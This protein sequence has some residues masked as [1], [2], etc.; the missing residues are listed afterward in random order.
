MLQALRLAFELRK[1]YNLQMTQRAAVLTGDLIA[2][3]RAGR[4]ATDAA[5]TLIDRIAR[6]E[7]AQAEASIGFSRFRGDGW[8]IFCSDP[9][10]VFRLAV[11]V[12]AAL[13]SQKKLPGTRISAATGPFTTAPAD[14]AGA[15]G[16]VFSLSGRNL[17]SM[18]RQ[19]LVFDSTAEGT[20]WQRALFAYL[21]WQ[22]RRWSP[23]QAEAIALAFRR[24]PPQPGTSAEDLGITRQAF[25]A[26]LDGAGYVPLW[27]A[28]RVF[29][30][31]QKAS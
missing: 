16:E 20:G 23:E 24:D 31:Q 7:G 8:Q 21:D 2:S 25:S 15:A 19:R 10:R 18:G 27:E 14:L 3:T 30:Q 6:D 17:D 4:E 5:I 11:R 13:Q 29:R 26:R 22:S 12:L 9:G 28:E 1:P